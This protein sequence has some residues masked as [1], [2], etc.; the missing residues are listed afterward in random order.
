MI[1]NVVNKIIIFYYRMIPSYIDCS[2]TI[3]SIIVKCI[4]RYCFYPCTINSTTMS[5]ITSTNI[6]NRNVIIESRII[7]II[8]IPNSTT[9]TTSIINESTIRYHTNR[10]YST[11]IS[12]RSS[13]IVECGIRYVMSIKN[14]TPIRPAKL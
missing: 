14:T 6:N 7:Y 5:I 9:M 12:K 2:T 3:S 11:I 10:R 8:C 1:C 13:I 4:I